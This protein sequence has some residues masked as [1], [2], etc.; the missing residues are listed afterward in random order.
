MSMKHHSKVRYLLLAEL[1]QKVSLLLC[2]NTHAFAVFFVFREQ[3]WASAVQTLSV[4]LPERTTDLAV[5]EILERGVFRRC[6]M[7]TSTKASPDKVSAPARIQSTLLLSECLLMRMI[8][9]DD[10]QPNVV[11][12]T[13]LLLIVAVRCLPSKGMPKASWV[14]LSNT[15]GKLS[16]GLTPSYWC[17]DLP[18][19]DFRATTLIWKKVSCDVVD[20]FLR[21]E[22]NV[23]PNVSLFQTWRLRGQDGWQIV[24]AEHHVWP[25]WVCFFLTLALQTTRKLGFCSACNNESKIK[26]QRTRGTS[27]EAW[28]SQHPLF[29]AAH[30]PW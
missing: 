12:A 1:W 22:A 19:V 14:I 24:P 20:G 23:S 26:D 21:T 9:G 11:S 27:Q 28:C 16:S 3:T 15:F 30:V 17:K 18:K 10:W 29:H 13:V 25:A 5:P 7:R 8:S 2:L 6:T 4:H